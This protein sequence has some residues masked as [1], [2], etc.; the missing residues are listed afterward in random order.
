MADRPRPYSTRRAR[1]IPPEFEETFVRQG[2]CKVNHLWGKRA[3]VRYFTALGSQ[4]L[5]A[6][7]DAYL[8]TERAE[9]KRAG[10]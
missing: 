3:A 8:E 4:R 1:P 5:R 7:R 2:W 6:A 9:K 10:R